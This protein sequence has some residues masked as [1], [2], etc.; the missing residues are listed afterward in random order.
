M[1]TRGLDYT[2]KALFCHSEATVFDFPDEDRP[3]TEVRWGAYVS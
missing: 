1:M 2:L 3:L